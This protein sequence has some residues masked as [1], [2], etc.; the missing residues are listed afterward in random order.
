MSLRVLE[1]GMSTTA[2]DAGRSGYRQWGLATGG[3]LDLHAFRWANKLLDNPMNAA[4]LEIVL[5]GF[6]AR[7]TGP[8]SLSLTGAVVPAT[9][10]GQQIDIWKSHRLEP[11]DELEL[12]Y[13]RH[14][15]LIYLAL[16]GGI[17]SPQLFGSRSVVAREG[18]SRNRKLLEVDCV[19][20]LR[21]STHPGPR[22]VPYPHR[23]QYDLDEVTL[24]L[25]PGYQFDQFTRQD[26]ARLTH[27]SWRVSQQS[28]RMGYRLEGP[29]LEEVPP[30]IVSEGIAVGA[31]QVPGDGQP[32]VLLPDC[33][34]IGGYPKPGTVPLADLGKLAQRLPG[35]A[36]GF[37]FC[38]IE[39]VQAE[40]VLTERYFT[41]AVWSRE[42][43]DLFWEA[44]ETNRR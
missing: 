27:T 20:P 24:R 41:S 23:G 6:R 1:P 36:V 18:I 28:D 30:G 9:I 21:P 5:G 4:C 29:A 32:I 11:G 16:P 22:Q 37:E 26:L 13:S 40:R 19:A 25:I 43:D 42:G 17:D 31:L 10:N 3:A 39:D 15:R 2:Q 38:A 12:G 7:A 35:Q 8:V 14:G 34:T 33:Q 44:T